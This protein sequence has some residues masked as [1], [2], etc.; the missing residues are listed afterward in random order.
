MYV[1]VCV[2]CCCIDGKSFS[3]HCFRRAHEYPQLDVCAGGAGVCMCARMCANMNRAPRTTSSECDD[4]TVSAVPYRRNISRA[5]TPTQ[6]HTFIYTQSVAVQ[7]RQ[8]QEK[9]KNLDSEH[10]RISL[11]PSVYFTCPSRTRQF[12][13][14]T[15]KNKKTECLRIYAT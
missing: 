1:C 10:A 4:D 15:Q 9:G 6:S 12:Q 2:G 14:T 13:A 8:Q 7:F 11:V 3:V 5:H